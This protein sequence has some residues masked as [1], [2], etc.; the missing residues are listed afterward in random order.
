MSKLRRY[1]RDGDFCFVTSVTYQRRPILIE[2]AELLLKAILNTQDRVSF[3]MIA[4]VIMP[5]HFHLLIE[6]GRN[7]LSGIMQRVKQS[8]SMNYRK[9]SG[10]AGRVWQLRFWDHIIRDEN[11]F[12]NHVDYI[13]YNPVKHGLTANPFDYLY[14]SIHEYARAGVYQ[15]D[16][17]AKEPDS[18][19]GDYG[20]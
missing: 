11:D 19:M 18:L 1:H 13:H 4:H 16:W 2:H 7:D 6:V 12:N 17:G 20:E 10:I 14:S 5:D 15:S 8:F 9:F 3:G